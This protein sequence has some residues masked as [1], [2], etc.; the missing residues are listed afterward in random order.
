MYK[1]EPLPGAPPCTVVIHADPDTDPAVIQRA[2]VQL[3]GPI[4]SFYSKARQAQQLGGLP[5][6]ATHQALPDAQMRYSYNNGQ[7]TVHVQLREVTST[8]E[9][10]EVVVKTEPWDTILVELRIPGTSDTG[11]HMGAWLVPQTPGQPEYATTDYTSRAGSLFHF[12]TELEPITETRDGATWYG[13]LKI[14]ITGRRGTLEVDIYGFIDKPSPPSVALGAWVI[15]PYSIPIVIPGTTWDIEVF[16]PE[17]VQLFG[18][19]TRAQVDAEYPELTGIP[20][21]SGAHDTVAA[22]S[23]PITGGSLDVF[24]LGEA[25]ILD[26]FRQFGGDYHKEVQTWANGENRIVKEHGTQ[27]FVVVGG[28]DPP[29]I[30]GLPEGFA[31]GVTYS[32]SGASLDSYFMPGFDPDHPPFDSLTG[33]LSTL[34]Y[35]HGD[36]LDEV[37]RFKTDGARNNNTSYRWENSAIYPTRSSMNAVRDGTVVVPAILPPEESSPENHF[38]MRKLGT[39]LFDVDHATAKWK[40]A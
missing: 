34:F 30:P 35:R 23:R 12:A 7:E 19:Y 24:L 9:G 36:P 29:F 14:N 5:Q 39:F 13:S 2:Y 8:S 15:H 11:A 6:Y 4:G 28:P 20:T 22:R 17:V 27:W 1:P 31:P 38:G 18:G 26:Y 33:T 10:G 32:L 16:E 37:T 40:P 21:D 25:N 3:L